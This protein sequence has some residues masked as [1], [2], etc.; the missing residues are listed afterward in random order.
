MGCLVLSGLVEA[1]GS[2]ALSHVFL[3]AS[4]D[5]KLFLFLIKGYMAVFTSPISIFQLCLSVAF[6]PVCFYQWRVTFLAS[7][8]VDLPLQYPSFSV[9]PCNR[10]TFLS[11]ECR[12]VLSLS[13]D[14][15]GSMRGN[16]LH[17][18]SVSSRQLL[19]MKHLC[20]NGNNYGGRNQEPLTSPIF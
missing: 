19:Q 10:E 16:S 9:H 1:V 20:S 11:A 15:H 7:E 17:I 3:L 18:L 2:W 4:M 6:F 5:C 13:Y 8:V 14:T 12:F